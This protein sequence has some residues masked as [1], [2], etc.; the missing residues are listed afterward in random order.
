MGGAVITVSTVR[1]GTGIAV[2]GQ[3]GAQ[4]SIP[5]NLIARNDQAGGSIAMSDELDRSGGI[6][7]AVIATG[8][9]PG[10]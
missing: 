9:R 5:T 10:P 6:G 1:S 8:D 7:P 3:L 2:G 4:Q